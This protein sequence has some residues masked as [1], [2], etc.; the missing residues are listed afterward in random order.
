[1][2]RLQIP[3]DQVLLNP[4]DFEPEEFDSLLA[5]FI[6]VSEKHP[7]VLEVFNDHKQFF[8]F[9][10]EGQPYWATERAGEDFNAITLKKFFASLRKLQFPQV[11]VYFTNLVLYHS[12]LVYLQKKPE[13]KIDS[14]LVD[15]DELLD[16][17]EA[18]KS[19]A[20]V[21]AYQPGNFIVLRYQEGKAIACYHC[22]CE[23]E[24]PEANIREEFLVKVYTLSTHCSFRINL[25]TDLVVSHAE[26][27]RPFP[28]DYQGSV[29]SFYLSQ[30]PKLIVKL[31]NR[32][33]KT[34]PFTGRAITIG[35]LAQ[36][37]IVIDNLSV[38]RMHA[39]IS[40]SKDGYT[41]TDLGSKNG[42]Y[43]NGNLVETSRLNSDDRITIGKYEIIFQI[44]CDLDSA[45]Q[46][47]DQTVIIPNYHTDK[48]KEEFHIQFPECS[49]DTPRLFRQLN[50]EE[51]PLNTEKTVIGKGKDSDIRLKG[52][53][54]PRVRVE[55]TQQ[56]DAYVLQKVSGRKRLRINGEEMDEKVLEEEDLIA[57]GS[58]EFVFKR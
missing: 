34:Y 14:S 28:A 49:Q 53:L 11:V 55:I 50:H 32:P 54:A 42:T 1:M 57:I 44:P 39:S 19:S 12:L 16:K 36:N 4:R 43:V 35:R 24:Q 2:S 15:F 40:K 51:Y 30:P 5:H 45:A 22:H 48:E 23:N 27:S 26:D 25:F 20:V 10:N 21:T 46:D 37:D 17:T 58:E 7:L 13:L 41:L 29:T 8:V 33:L 6:N 31:K 9:I 56:G 52:L 47:M 38:S 18:D 3:Y